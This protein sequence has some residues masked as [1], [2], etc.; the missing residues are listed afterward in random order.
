MVH[1]TFR[2][3]DGMEGV[4]GGKTKCVR[5]LLDWRPPIQGDRSIQ[6]IQGY[7]GVWCTISGLSH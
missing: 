6:L 4:G 7:E 5:E 2:G 1:N 3:L